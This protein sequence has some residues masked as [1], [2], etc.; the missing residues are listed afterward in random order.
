MKAPGVLVFLC[1]IGVA[2]AAAA[3][4]TKVSGQ[5]Q[6]GK[7]DEAHKIEVGDWPTHTMSL[8]KNACTWTKPIE[9]A[10]EQA[11]GGVSVSSA[12]RSG[13]KAREHGSHY[14]TMS[15]GD[16][17][18]VRYQSESTLKEETPESISGTFTFA[19]GTGKMKNLKGKGTLK[20]A[21]PPTAEGAITFDIE[22]E[23]GLPPAAPGAATT[24]GQ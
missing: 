22:G 23:Y 11:K 18:Y 21:G 12:E 13:N 3:Q 16:K 1:G 14:D 17:I 19:G 6:C 8:S 24:P 15:N 20:S 4:T 2:T 7:P 10:G 5:L 9:I